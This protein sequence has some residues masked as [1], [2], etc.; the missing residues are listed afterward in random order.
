MLAL[1]IACSP[2]TSI[3]VHFTPILG[4][5]HWM[6]ADARISW[7]LHASVSTL[8]TSPNPVCLSGL[9]QLCCLSR[10]LHFSVGTRLLPLPSC[11]GRTGGDCTFSRSRLLSGT[12]CHFTSGMQ[13]PSMRSSQLSVAFL[14]PRITWLAWFLVGFLAFFFFFFFFL[15]M[16][17]FLLLYLLFVFFFFFSSRCY[18]SCCYC[19]LSVVDIVLVVNC[20]YYCCCRQFYSCWLCSKKQQPPPPSYQTTCAVVIVVVF[21]VS[22]IPVCAFALKNQ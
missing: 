16:L 18:C 12:H 7:I 1:Y 9:P 20:S 11:R 13:Q 14:R 8:L 19:W 3:T 15:C 10:S 5:P 22:F 6:P 4:Q 17:L 21:V 2:Y